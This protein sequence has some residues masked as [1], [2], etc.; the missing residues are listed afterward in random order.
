MEN[1]LKT[2]DKRL[3]KLQQKSVFT[4]FLP[5]LSFSLSII[6]FLLI[7]ATQHILGFGNASIL[8][9][10]LHSQYICFIQQFLQTLKGNGSF[11]YSFSNYL[12]S[13][14]ILTYAYYALNPFNL[15]YLIDTISISTIT[16]VIITLKIALSA[17]TFQLYIKN[18]LKQDK[19]YTIIFSCSYSLCSYIV[20]QYHNIMWLDA[21]YLL[22]II[23]ILT[24]RLVDKQKA[25]L[26]IPA[27][28]YLYITNFYMAFIVGIFSAIIFITYSCY[29][30]NPYERSSW[31]QFFKNGLS[32]AGCAI[33][34]AGLCAAILLPAALFLFGNMAEDNFEFK[35]LVANFPDMIN[36]MFI[37]Q[38]QTMDTQVPLLYCGLPVLAL[39]PF[40]FINSDIKHKEKIYN[41]IIIAFLVI[42]MVFMPLYKLMHAFDYP[43]FYGFR[44][45]FLL[46]FV[47]LSIACRESK[48]ILKLPLKTLGIFFLGLTVFYSF[49]I[50]FQS[51]KFPILKTNTQEE[52]VLNSLFLLIWF[53]AV[54]LIQKKSSFKSI[55][56]VAVILIM[57]IELVVNGYLCINKMEHPAT[58]ESTFNQ[59]YYSA[60]EAVNSIKENDS[61]FYRIHLNNHTNYNAA[62][63]LN[64]AGLTTF[65]SSDNYNLRNTLSHLGLVTSNRYISEYGMTDIT[66]MLFA[67]KYDINLVRAE[68]GTGINASNYVSASSIIEN[69]YALSLGYMVSPLIENYVA[70]DDPFYNQMMLIYYMTGNAYNFYEPIDM[71]GISIEYDNMAI[72]YNLGSVEFYPLSDSY[73]GGHIFFSAP[74][75]P[76]KNFMMCFSRSESKAIHES[77]YVIAEVRGVADPATISYGAIHKAV[78]TDSLYDEDYDLMVL[79]F[80]DSTTLIDYCNNIYAYYFNS[81]FLPTIYDD[82]A[83]GNLKIQ[84]FSQDTI[85]G[86]VTVTAERP[87]LFTSIPYENG[88]QAYVDGNPTDIYPVVGN[89]FLALVLTPGEHT[90]ELRY[91][92][93]GSDI[94]M[95]ISE[96]S[97][98]LLLLILLFNRKRLT[99]NG[100]TDETNIN[101]NAEQSNTKKETTHSAKEQC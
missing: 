99:N 83:P 55:L 38:M 35:M 6:I 22:P 17:A 14:T 29:R 97:S 65:S 58:A 69:P 56:S 52:L 32:F 71:D 78:T 47:F 98:I 95:L 44:F 42:S 10:D 11:W 91:T 88:W 8:R 15:L 70:S 16:A 7:L 72:A 101:K 62:S 46:V 40:Y 94:G 100:S 64:F 13:G 45:A 76:G 12:G 37:G 74:T 9:S 48:H 61:D 86:T 4:G 63:L 24:C 18:V 84:S 31:R 19:L 68:A 30:L 73:G 54:L 5:L 1:I 90:V 85:V 59:Y 75:I 27:F 87:V 89:A 82:L 96:A 80:S 36:A 2:L 39:L 67:A 81:T 93:P 49:M 79:E 23:I 43:N 41:G 3:T 33:L 20:A 25:L 28:A 92:A 34:A 50:S 77:A 21:L 57:S 51:I 66:D 26:L 60:S 53:L